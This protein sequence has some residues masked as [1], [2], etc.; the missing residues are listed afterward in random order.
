MEQK[1]TDEPAA[2]QGLQDVLAEFAAEVMRYSAD[3]MVSL[4]RHHN[5]SMPRVSAMMCVERRGAASISTISERLDLSLAA[6]SQ[7]VDQLVCAGFVTRTEDP[8]DRRTKLIKLTPAGAAFTAEVRRV[9]VEEL[10]RQLATL[11][12]PLLNDLRTTL[13]QVLD[14]MRANKS[15][16]AER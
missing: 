14:H 16:A 13:E 11:P 6:T 3:D 15:P 10:A 9:R 12:P 2:P 5:L 7:L 1:T 8:H 4:V